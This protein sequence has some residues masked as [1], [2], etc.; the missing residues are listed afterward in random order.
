[1]RKLTQEQKD[2]LKKTFDE[3]QEK[4]FGWEDLPAK[5]CRGLILLNDYETLPQDVSRYISDKY[6]EWQNEQPTRFL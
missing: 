5:V 3:A 6:F 1:M 4:P 2:L